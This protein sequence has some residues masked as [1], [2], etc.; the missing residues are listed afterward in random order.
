MEFTRNAE[1]HC[2]EKTSLAPGCVWEKS[3]QPS[4]RSSSGGCDV[5]E[6]LGPLSAVGYV[7]KTHSP[8]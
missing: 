4:G 6:A 2:P 3:G 8:W 7:F 1:E 5:L